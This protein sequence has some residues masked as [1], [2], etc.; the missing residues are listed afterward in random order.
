[1]MLTRASLIPSSTIQLSR[2]PTY[3]NASRDLC[4]GLSILSIP[5]ARQ[6]RSSPITL[7]TI[8][9]SPVSQGSF[10]T[11]LKPATHLAEVSLSRR[12]LT[13]ATEPGSFLAVPSSGRRSYHTG[14]RNGS[15][16]INQSSCHT[17]SSLRKRSRYSRSARSQYRA[18]SS[19]RYLML[20]KPLSST[21]LRS[22]RHG[23]TSTKRLTT[24]SI[25]AASPL[26]I[27][28]TFKPSS[29]QI[30]RAH[31]AR[32]SFPRSSRCRIVS[33]CG[34]TQLFTTIVPVPVTWPLMATHIGSEKDRFHR[35][36]TTAAAPRYTFTST[37][38]RLAVSRRSRTSA[39]PW[40]TLTTIMESQVGCD[41]NRS[42]FHPA[43]KTGL[44]V[45]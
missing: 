11:A 28:G 20:S 1:M 17:A 22:K 26:F 15:S 9:F 31:T 24:C 38:P 29:A 13:T 14:P 6:S 23:P 44:M 45:G 7:H 25:L 41:L 10:G 34:S 8:S 42:R 36:I 18:S 21:R 40:Y 30:L 12:T 2:R 5:S 3:T 19:K 37:T 27:R 39:I 33:P 35:S 43:F 4:P 16:A 32:A